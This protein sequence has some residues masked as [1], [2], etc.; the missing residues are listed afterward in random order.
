MDPICLL[1]NRDDDCDGRI[2]NAVIVHIIRERPCPIGQRFDGLASQP[3]GIVDE[4]VYETGIFARTKSFDQ[5]D[6]F[7]LT[8]A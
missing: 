2:V 5:R 8:G 1:R 3:F 7:R 6:Q 4:I